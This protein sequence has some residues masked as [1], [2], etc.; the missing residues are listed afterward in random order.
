MNR[1]KY[2]AAVKLEGP[3]GN[4]MRQLTNKIKGI[5]QTHPGNSDLNNLQKEMEK[6]NKA[7]SE[8][9]RLISLVP[10]ALM[11]QV[12]S[13]ESD[14]LDDFLE[15]LAMNG[16][17]AERN[18]QK[19]LKNKSDKLVHAEKHGWSFRYKPPRQITERNLYMHRIK[20]M[21]LQRELRRLVAARNDARSKKTMY[22]RF[23]AKKTGENKKLNTDIAKLRAQLTDEFPLS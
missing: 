5:L 18:R 17:Q 15:K 21:Q 16:G 9:R 14:N 10:N 8:Q 22:Q 12:L 4:R 6:L 19:R 3:F 23:V 2:I 1:Q 7:Q 11:Y 20:M 13:A